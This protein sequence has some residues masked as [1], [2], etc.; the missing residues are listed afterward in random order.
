MFREGGQPRGVWG[1]WNT[2][3]LNGGP[4]L[5]IAKILHILVQNGQFYAGGKYV[6]GDFPP[7]TLGQ[8]SA[9]MSS[10]FLFNK[11]YS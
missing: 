8:W 2:S 7:P 1:V 11:D 9:A 4:G 3:K 5:Q 10:F 6:G